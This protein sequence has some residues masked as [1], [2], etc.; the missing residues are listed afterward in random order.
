MWD[1]NGLFIITPISRVV[2]SIRLPTKI[3]AYLVSIGRLLWLAFLYIWRF[4]NKISLD[5]ALTLTSQP[6]I[7]NLPDNPVYQA[8][9]LNIHNINQ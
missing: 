8:K 5:W 2:K 9:P 3:A 7:S 1:R 6:S 4:L